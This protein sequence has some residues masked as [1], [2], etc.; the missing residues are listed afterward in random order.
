MYIAGPYRASTVAGIRQNIENARAVAE[1]WVKQDGWYPVTPHLN[2]AFMDG[3]VDDGKFLDG[4]LNLL[5]K[6]D[7]ICL[8]K[9]WEKSA[10]T[11]AEVEKAKMLNIPVFRTIPN[12]QEIEG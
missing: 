8:V 2:T 7:A 12:K 4:A 6:C 3:I 5:E 10:G 9:G 1:Y 11:L